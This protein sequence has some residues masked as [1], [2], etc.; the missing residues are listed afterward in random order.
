MDSLEESSGGVS[1]RRLLLGAGGVVTILGGATLVASTPGPPDGAPTEDPGDPTGDGSNGPAAADTGAID[2]T[3]SISDARI[4]TVDGTIP[5]LP[6]KLSGQV[7]YESVGAQVDSLALAVAASLS[8]ADLTERP[9]QTHVEEYAISSTGGLGPTNGELDF[10]LG[11]IDLLESASVDAAS[12]DATV[13]NPTTTTVHVLL[14]ASLL[15]EDETA[16]SAG[17][18][19]RFNVTV[20]NRPG[21]LN[22]EG[23]GEILANESS[24]QADP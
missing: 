18:P 21:V 19:D 5:A 20:V 9:N 22:V 7:Q 11:P 4:E 12:F 15:A 14:H 24:E 16:L 8:E 1:R 23:E 10:Q 13:G 17:M 2:G 6:F 3:I